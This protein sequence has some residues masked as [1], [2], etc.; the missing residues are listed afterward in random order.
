MT[1]PRWILMTLAVALLTLACGGG[2]DP[3]ADVAAAN[4]AV[5]AQQKTVDTAKKVVAE[6]AKDVAKAQEQLAAAQKAQQDEE[7]ELDRL[8]AAVDRSAL[9][10]ALFRAVQQRLL[11]DKKLANVA[12]T[13]SVSQGVVT[14]SGAVDSQELNDR[15]T[16]VAGETRG[17]ERVE[18]RIRIHAPAG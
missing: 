3:V 16:K 10:T 7:R 17:V 12:I 9:D 14:L 5:A 8:A 6:R 11:Q 2:S 15:A 13:A 18:S 1:A 4:A